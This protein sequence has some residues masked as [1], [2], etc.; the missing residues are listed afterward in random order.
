MC[1]HGSYYDARVDACVP[2]SPNHFNEKIEERLRGK[3]FL[4]AKEVFSEKNPND[5]IK[6][7]IVKRSIK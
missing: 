7:E 2:I 6:K 5:A 1:P 4:P 3:Q